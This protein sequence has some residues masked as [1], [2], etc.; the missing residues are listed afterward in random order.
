MVE[1]VSENKEEKEDSPVEGPE[2]AQIEGE[3][4]GSQQQEKEEKNEDLPPEENVVITE[5]VRD[6]QPAFKRS[7]TMRNEQNEARKLQLPE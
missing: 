2:Q 3:P 6:D 1:P 7:H 5:A 4:T